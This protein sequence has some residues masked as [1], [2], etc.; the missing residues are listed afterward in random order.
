MTLFAVSIPLV[1]YQIYGVAVPLVILAALYGFRW[2]AGMW[3]N[4]VTLGAVL[5]S[6]LIAFGWWEDAAYLLAQQVPAMCYIADCVAFWTLFLVSLL[7]LDTATRSMSSIKVKYND[8]VENVGN[9]IALFLLFL[10]LLGVH[11]IAN[12]HMG[13]VGE[14]KNPPANSNSGANAVIS[15]IRL[16][17]EGNLSTFTSGN[18]FDDTGKFLNRHLQRRQALMTNAEKA[19][20]PWQQI[21]YSG[22]SV[23]PRVGSN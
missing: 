6:I 1:L 7:I 18:Q 8:I 3:G 2:K 22:G 5:F 19:E 4:C 17:S 20:G 15:V 12:G 14:V 10:A 21:Q 9:G 11:S 23:P 16:L 13:M